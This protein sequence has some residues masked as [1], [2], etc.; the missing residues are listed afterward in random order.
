MR[1]FGLGGIDTFADQGINGKNCEFHAAMGLCNLHHIDKILEKR[2]YLYNHY[3][4]R[5]KRLKVEFPLICNEDEYNH[6][7]FP[8]IFKNEEQLKRA[9]ERLEIAQVYCRRY[10]YPSLSSLPYVTNQ[11]MPICDSISSRILCLPMYHT[12]TLSE[13]DLITRLLLRA[14]D[15]DNDETAVKHKE[16]LIMPPKSTLLSVNGTR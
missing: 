2:K 9:K 8:I 14:Q 13:L 10:F 1:N 12:L 4:L 11:W 3:K 15:F 16:L 5:L 7:Y 6:A